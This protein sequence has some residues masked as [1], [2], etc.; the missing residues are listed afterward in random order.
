MESDLPPIAARDFD[1]TSQLFSGESVSPA[2]SQSAIT[3]TDQTT[4]VQNLQAEL[5]DSIEDVPIV[6]SISGNLSDSTDELRPESPLAESAESDSIS[7]GKTRL[8]YNGENNK[9]LIRDDASNKEEFEVSKL[10]NSVLKHESEKSDVIESSTDQILANPETNQ[11]AF[12]SS[13]VVLAAEEQGRSEERHNLNVSDLNSGVIPHIQSSAD[14]SGE[15]KFVN[16]TSLDMTTSAS[17]SSDSMDSVAHQLDELSLSKSDVLLH[18]TSS[19][20]DSRAIIDG[21]EIITDISP[22]AEYTALEEGDISL[23]APSAIQPIDSFQE[24]KSK[25]SVLKSSTDEKKMGENIQLE[26]EL[27]QSSVLDVGSSSQPLIEPPAAEVG[28]VVPKSLSIDQSEVDIKNSE[29][30]K[31]PEENNIDFSLFD[32]GNQV[33]SGKESFY[34]QLQST[35][36]SNELLATPSE[37]A[38]DQFIGDTLFG[39]TNTAPSKADAFFDQIDSKQQSMDTAIE[40]DAQ[41]SSTTVKVCTEESIS[42]SDHDFGAQLNSEIQAEQNADV[43]VEVPSK[44]ESASFPMFDNDAPSFFDQISETATHPSVQPTEILKTDILHSQTN[45]DVSN[46][47][48]FASSGNDDFL[49][50]N[51]ARSSTG[52]MLPSDPTSQL[53]ANAFDFLLD[54]TDFLPDDDGIITSASDSVPAVSTTEYAP[55]PAFAGST[56]GGSIYGSSNM[57]NIYSS[58]SPYVSVPL[59]PVQSETIIAPPAREVHKK[60]FFEELPIPKNPKLLR[61]IDQY[62]KP[63]DS[64]LEPLISAERPFDSFAQVTMAAAPYGAVAPTSVVSTPPPPVVNPYAPPPSQSIR[65]A[66]LTNDSYTPSSYSLV[67]ETMPSQN[68]FIPAPG[69]SFM[70]APSYSQSQPGYLA[71]RDPVLVGNV[72]EPSASSVNGYSEQ[73]AASSYGPIVPPIQQSY[74]PGAASQIPPPPISNPYA[75]PSSVQSYSAAPGNT[76]DPAKNL[77]TGPGYTSISHSTAPSFSGSESIYNN[78]SASPLHPPALNA[79]PKGPPIRSHINDNASDA[80]D[81]P[82]LSGSSYTFPR[83]I[84]SQSAVLTMSGVKSNQSLSGAYEPAEVERPHTTEPSYSNTPLTVIPSESR[85]PSEE[86][87]ATTPAVSAGF[88]NLAPPSSVARSTVLSPRPHRESDRPE[89]H[90]L[91]NW[92]MTGRIVTIFPSQNQQLGYAATHLDFSHSTIKDRSVKE[93]V[94][95]L[96]N[97]IVLSKFPG[98]V[99]TI[100]S[101]SANKTKK[102]EVLKWLDLKIPELAK[103]VYEAIGAD[104]KRDAE[105]KLTL[106]KCV[107]IILDRDGDMLAN[108]DILGKE[109]RAVLIPEL[110]IEAASDEMKNFS[111]ATDI[112]QRHARHVSNYSAAGTAANNEKA[113]AVSEIYRA[114]VNGDREVAL[115]LAIDH[116]LWDQALLISSTISKERYQETSHEFV[117]NEVV[118]LRTSEAS[119]LAVLYE[120]FSGNAPESIDSLLPTGT[121]VEVLPANASPADTPA[122]LLKWREVLAMI[123]SN[124]SPDDLEAIY[125]LGVAL[126]AYGLTYAAHTCFIFAQ[127]LAMFGA[128]DDPNARFTLL[129]VDYLRNKTSFGK[130]LDSMILSEIFELALSLS[131]SAAVQSAGFPHLQLF[132]YQHAL[133]LGEMGYVVEA[134]RYC[135]AI[136]SAIKSTPKTAFVYNSVFVQSVRELS[137]RLSETPANE[138]SGWLGGIM[139]KPSLGNVWGTFDKKLAQFVAGN[140]G[141]S[142]PNGSIG[143][144]GGDARF[145]KLASTSPI[146]SRTHS[147]TDLKSLASTPGP[148]IYSGSPTASNTYNPRITYGT[149]P[150]SVRSVSGHTM[151]NPYAPSGP[152]QQSPAA[153]QYVPGVAPSRSQT[154]SPYAPSRYAPSA[155]DIPQGAHIQGSGSNYSRPGSSLATRP[156]SAASGIIDDTYSNSYSGFR[157]SSEGRIQSDILKPLTQQATV[158]KPEYSVYDPYKADKP[159]T[160]NPYRAVGGEQAIPADSYESVSG[161]NNYEPPAADYESEANGYEPPAGNYEPA[162]G[163]YAPY[164][165]DYYSS[166]TAGEHASE[167]APPKQADRPNS[168]SELNESGTEALREQTYGYDDAYSRFSSSYVPV[169]PEEVEDA[170]DEEIEAVEQRHSGRPQW[171]EDDEDDLGLGNNALRKKKINNT[172]KTE[173]ENADADTDADTDQKKQDKEDSKESKEQ[174]SNDAGGVQKAGWFSWMRRGKDTEEKPKAIRA[175]LGNEIK[176]VY[177]KDL[178][179]WINPNDPDAGK[180]AAA[181]PPPP[182]SRKAAEPTQTSTHESTSVS[183]PPIIPSTAP[184]LAMTSPNGIPNGQPSRV[185]TLPSTSGGPPIGDTPPGILGSSLSGMPELPQIA[186]GASRGTKKRPRYIPPPAL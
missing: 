26:A 154:V 23:D 176:F 147:I 168:N 139:G 164:G 151:I 143:S 146:V 185:A 132:K 71:S 178:K 41:A 65:P 56:Y 21:S 125:G 39:N 38:I 48:D 3:A 157:R 113:K 119:S 45:P 51:T 98:P 118:S 30:M 50:G 89:P 92:T 108:A 76:Y 77:H 42:D 47:I 14:S 127:P 34:S 7:A 40:H 179:R 169:E 64:S 95:I 105:D 140:E 61:R 36:K 15:S 22:V 97:D 19:L 25:D 83:R 33:P 165:N 74:I 10:E 183:A 138:S 116:N 80:Y 93:L 79:P 96:A 81:P 166:F 117:K 184:P 99:F 121:T 13:P 106:W 130:D 8:I 57:P 49:F 186:S 68:S 174:K 75:P 1:S 17:Q 12:V 123:L 31:S 55:T 44:D 52:H 90:P 156:S 91:F 134:R 111:S 170:V 153:N 72:H 73:N 62:Q 101:K 141:E 112:Y 122:Q 150:S 115:T 131:S 175:K 181:P 126:S 155:V 60:S 163:N 100:G 82:F 5:P 114:L 136:A 182:M 29:E 102:K 66:P 53:Q 128:V 172:G 120:I 88:S 148:S 20:S 84:S 43:P 137:Q 28:H 4:R 103:L 133:I 180:A 87:I 160:V 63:S 135:E 70:T 46:G 37:S 58:Q 167:S 27:E 152:S 173:S 69:I 162:S 94:P 78:T 35:A 129:G 16:S 159:S 6:R 144:E 107:R 149:S 9:E 86:F 109:I 171:D 59:P 11:S 54:D 145:R 124:R 67:T 2:E 18:D 142:E 110:S 158:P 85:L 177:D 32:N 104:A 24:N 161:S